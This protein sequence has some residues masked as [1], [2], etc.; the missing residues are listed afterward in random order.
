MIKL[1]FRKMNNKKINKIYQI[2]IK[3]KLLL[4]NKRIKYLNY[5]KK[6]NY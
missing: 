5:N 3:I 1:K 2:I 4:R 6:L